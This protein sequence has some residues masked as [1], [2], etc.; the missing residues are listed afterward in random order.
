MDRRGAPGHQL[1]RAAGGVSQDAIRDPVRARGSHR[2]ADRHRPGPRHV[3]QDYRGRGHRR[4][5]DGHGALALRRSADRP[6]AAHPARAAPARRGPARS[7][8][9]PTDP[10]EREPVLIRLLRD[11]LR[12]YRRPLAAV[13]VL[14][15]VQTLATLYL[16]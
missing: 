5:S 10:A 8:P 16:P 6:G 15:L 13:V 3:P 12:P 7:L 4:Y 11:Y 1:A 9:N 14:Q 2:R